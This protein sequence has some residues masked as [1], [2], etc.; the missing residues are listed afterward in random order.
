VFSAELGPYEGQ[1]ETT[2]TTHPYVVTSDNNLCLGIFFGT[3]NMGR[4][5]AIS[6]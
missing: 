2:Q 3:S 1:L 5:I 4:A 6:P